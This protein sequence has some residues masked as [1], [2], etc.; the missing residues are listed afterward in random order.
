VQTHEV[1]QDSINLPFMAC[2]LERSVL[3]LAAR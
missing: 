2:S 3:P 1:S